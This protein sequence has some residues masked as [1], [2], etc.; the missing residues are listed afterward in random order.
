METQFNQIIS[1]GKHNVFVDIS[2]VMYRSYYVFSP[3]KF[4]KKSDEDTKN[5]QEKVAKGLSQIFSLDY[6]ETLKKVT[7]SSS[8]ET[9]VQKV[10]KNKVSELK[11]WMESNNISSGIIIDQDT[12]RYYPY[13]NLASNLIGFCG[14][15]NQGLTGLEY[16]WE[17]TLAGTAGK[18]T[19]TQDS[20][21]DLMPNQDAQFFAAENGSNLTLTVDINIQSTVEKYLK[22]ACIT[23]KCGNGGNVIIMDPKTGDILAMATYPDYDLNTPFE[24]NKT[25]SDTWNNLSSQA[26]SDALQ[27]MCRNTAI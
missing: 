27:T 20:H 8:V 18:I 2:W 23:N 9:I 19:T 24:P 6:E 16:Y 12:K 1:N 7:S 21:Q 5:L 11:T 3:D 17:Q 15:D 26:Q 14:N 13:Y 25:L 4:K 22:Q 10:E